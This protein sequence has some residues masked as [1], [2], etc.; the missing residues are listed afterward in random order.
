MIVRLVFVPPFRDT[1]PLPDP[2]QWILLALNSH[3]PSP[4]VALL[5]F[6]LIELHHFIMLFIILGFSTLFG[7]VRPSGL[8]FAT[9]YCTAMGLGR[10]A[11]ILFFSATILPSPKPWCA[12]HRFDGT[13]SY[14][15]PWAQQYWK[16]YSHNHNI[17]W[18]LIQRDE[19]FGK[20]IPHCFLFLKCRCSR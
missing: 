5:R 14:P 4:L 12:A 15:N 11:R 7:Y 8:A 2:G 9:R 6:R 3:L 13:P 10:I 19:C 20:T 18:E 1:S 16:P 17:I